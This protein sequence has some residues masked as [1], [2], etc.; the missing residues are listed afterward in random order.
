[1]GGG[2]SKKAVNGV[3]TPALADEDL[4][5]VTE[6]LEIEKKD[7]KALAVLFC[8]IDKS[9][10][11]NINQHELFK[12]FKLEYDEFTG[13]VFKSMDA[14]QAGAQA[15]LTFIEFV[16]AFY[17]FLTS[18]IDSL[19]VL[20]FKLFDTDGGGD[21][22]VQEIRSMIRMVY[23]EEQVEKHTQTI[24][25]KLDK[26][27]DQRIGLR[28]FQKA[29]Q[30]APL[31]LEPMMHLQDKLRAKVFN[32]AYWKSKTKV[33]HGVLDAEQTVFE[34]YYKKGA[35]G[36]S[37][38]AGVGEGAGGDAAEWKEAFDAKHQRSYWYNTKTKETTWTKP[39][40]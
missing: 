30:A 5:T 31:L 25:K 37:A 10:N 29:E 12:H 27:G 26:G 8:K 3:L 38:M 2:P 28:E 33:R 39:T 35:K 40:S 13:R 24:L 32:N 17:N 1:M 23:G 4:K 22:G 34:L 18:T 15:E 7:L 19:V 9:G 36:P 21:I 20:T 6:A 16:L 14:E 11:G